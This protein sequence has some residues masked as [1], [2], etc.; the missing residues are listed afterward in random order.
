MALGVGENYL[1]NHNQTTVT[2]GEATPEQ[3]A[4]WNENSGQ[5]IDEITHLTLT[6]AQELYL[7]LCKNGFKLKEALDSCGF[8]GK[9]A[10]EAQQA[11]KIRDDDGIVTEITR[12]SFVGADLRGRDLQGVDLQHADLRDA[13][14]QGAVLLEAN[15]KDADLRDA[16][17]QGAVLLEA[18]LKDADLR[19]AD[20]R[21]ANL[22]GADL[23]GADL[24]W[25]VDL[26][27]ANLRGAQMQR[28]KL[29]GAD[30]RGADLRRAQM[31]NTDLQ[32]AKLNLTDLT[33][34]D[35]AY[36]QLDHVEW[37]LAFYDAANQ[38]ENL[39]DDILKKIEVQL[40]AF[41]DAANPPENPSD[42]ILKKIEVKLVALDQESYERAT[43]LQAD[44]QKALQSDNQEAIAAAKGPLTAYLEQCRR[45][46]ATKA[47]QQAVEETVFKAVSVLGRPETLRTVLT[48]IAS[49][50]SAGSA[51]SAVTITGA[52]Q[53]EAAK[54]SE[55][56]DLSLS[57]VDNRV[58][59]DI[60]PY[61]YYANPNFR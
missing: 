10:A 41:Y 53:A 14:M 6:P 33:A 50:G 27:G 45:D 7:A 30:L 29:F 22:W 61:E 35:F 12:P 43:E 19:G 49:A 37:D 28:A 39:S 32:H 1:T 52:S 40:V 20:L 31:Q 60:N 42:D 13:Q 47:I 56:Q 46:N 9:K 26:R 17:M 2:Q 44:Y 57:G 48:A 24:Q 34:A 23:R 51:G 15:L 16:Q 36:A 4:W 58:N 25:G 59:G 3:Q 18:N 54:P 21:W 5:P 8:K 38:P 11:L 55:Q